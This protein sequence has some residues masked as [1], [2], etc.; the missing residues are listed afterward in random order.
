MLLRNEGGELPRNADRRKA[1]AL[2]QL[3]PRKN[4]TEPY[5]G[6]VYGGYQGKHFILKA[7][8]NLVK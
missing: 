8:T 7:E 4:R 5:D 6:P 3:P 2:P 1:A